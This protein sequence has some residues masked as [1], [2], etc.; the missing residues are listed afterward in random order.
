MMRRPA[1]SRFL[2]CTPRM[3]HA[4]GLPFRFASLDSAATYW[5][6]FSVSYAVFAYLNSSHS[7]SSGNCR[8]ASRRRGRSRVAMLDCPAW[9][10]S[11]QPGHTK[12]GQ[13][14]ISTGGNRQESLFVSGCKGWD[15]WTRT[16]LEQLAASEEAI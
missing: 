9:R 7:A 10:E 12:L 11:V 4:S 16:K 13:Q 6:T 14:K 8:R 1:E 3:S 5:H 2:S 15:M